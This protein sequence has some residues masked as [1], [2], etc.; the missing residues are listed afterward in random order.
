[1]EKRE[2]QAA[3]S[4]SLII[5]PAVGD[6]P[7]GEPASFLFSISQ[8][9]DI[10]GSITFTEVPFSPAY[11]SG[12]SE[13]RGHALPVLS[14]EML[15]GLAGDDRAYKGTRGLVVR[16]T[17]PSD[18]PGHFRRALVRIAAGCRLVSRVPETEPLQLADYLPR[19]LLPAV[20]GMYRWESGILIVPHMDPVLSGELNRVFSDNA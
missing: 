12:I 15:L 10:L 7:Y 1:M 2:F 14:L 17:T 9:E 19:E 8:V 20:K 18:E 5:A 4:G 13:W 16:K 11:V 3:A 6:H